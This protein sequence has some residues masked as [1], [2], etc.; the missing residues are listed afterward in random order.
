MY[1]S[2]NANPDDS[3]ADPPKSG[4]IQKNANTAANST[5]SIDQ[6]MKFRG[7]SAGIKSTAASENSAVALSLLPDSVKSTKADTNYVENE[8]FKSNAFY[9]ERLL[10]QNTY[11]SKQARYRCLKPLTLIGEGTQKCQD[12]SLNSECLLVIFYLAF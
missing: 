1:D 2:F 10:N 7:A 5:T 9:M 4:P 6:S 8:N 11:Q 12:L 3:A